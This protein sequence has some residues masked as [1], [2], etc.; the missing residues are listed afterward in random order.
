MNKTEQETF[1]EAICGVV[2]HADPQCALSLAI[3]SALVRVLCRDEI[4]HEAGIDALLER[5][6]AYMTEE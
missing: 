2:T 5:G 3:V 4:G 6:W 1:K